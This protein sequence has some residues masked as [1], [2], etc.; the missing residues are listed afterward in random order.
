MYCTKC[1]TQNSDNVFKCVQCGEALSRPQQ[2]AASSTKPIE[3]A[4]YLVQAILLTIFCCLPF[5][6]PAIVFAAQVNTKVASGD[7]N[8]AIKSSRQ[9]KMWCW[10]SFGGGL[11][12]SLIYLLVMVIGLITGQ[13]SR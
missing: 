5:G 8:G 4:N 7:Y 1:G 13:A 3:I 6:I 2:F 9:A 10:I 12:I 11:G